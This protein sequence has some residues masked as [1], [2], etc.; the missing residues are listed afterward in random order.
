MR[1]I[2][3]LKGRDSPVCCASSDADADDGDGGG[4]GDDDDDDD[5]DDGGGDGADADAAVRCQAVHG[6]LR[7]DINMRSVGTASNIAPAYRAVLSN[8]YSS[9]EHESIEKPDD[10]DENPSSSCVT[11]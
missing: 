2:D 11:G 6:P 10:E 1:Q 5:D 7:Y 3:S 8:E 9:S 4:G